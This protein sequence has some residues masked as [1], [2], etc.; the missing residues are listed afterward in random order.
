MGYPLFSPVDPQHRIGSLLVHQDRGEI[1]RMAKASALYHALPMLLH[2]P[3][4]A[5]ILVLIFGRLVGRP[6]D[7]ISRLIEAVPPG[8]DRRIEM[9]AGHAN[10]EI[11]MLVNS[12]N[13]LLTATQQAIAEERRLRAEVDA[14][15]AHYRRIFET[16]SV[17]VMIIRS[18]GTLL[19]CN[20][21]LGSRII[22]LPKEV[23][24]QGN[25]INSVFKHPEKA[26]AL[27][28]QAWET[29]HPAAA[30]LQLQ[31][32]TDH[33]RWVH[34]MLSVSLDAYGDIEYI[35]GVLY[36][37]TA[38]RIKETEIRRAAE[39]DQ[40]TGLY[41]RR[42]IE[43]FLDRALVKA[44]SNKACV[45]IMLLDLDGFKAVNDTHGHAAGDV[46]LRVV[47][48]RLRSKIRKAEDAAARLGG[49]EFLVI[50]LTTCET[51]HLLLRIAEDMLHAIGEPIA[52]G[53]GVDV[54]VGASIG[55][56]CFPQDGH[57]REQL[58]LAA[59]AAM[60]QVKRSGKNGFALA[61]STEP[62]SPA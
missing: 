43:L 20:P 32:A 28:Q 52:V 17:G 31:T 49:D 13:A 27:V 2:I 9:P 40:L 4:S 36:D 62:A 14:L 30:D 5:G 45:G 3:L 41:N 7:R 51:N 22:D 57:G 24:A 29:G 16:T 59:D 53:D 18:D 10:N 15:Q 50:V 42:G 56:A 60:Y 44:S 11:G 46:V 54:Q 48:E 55:I 37:I 58:L 25:F 6:L 23:M 61:E 26:W 39:L 34:A 38:R 1:N 33:D 21:T 35:E 47:G 19:N 8:S 12:T